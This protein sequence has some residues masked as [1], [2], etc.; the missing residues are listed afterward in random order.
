MYGRHIYEG[1]VGYASRRK[2]ETDIQ[3]ETETV[4]ETR[5]NKGTDRDG[6]TVNCCSLFDP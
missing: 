3:K 5:I 2:I 6:E 4:A 1:G